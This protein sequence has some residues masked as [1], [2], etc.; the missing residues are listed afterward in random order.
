M[1]MLAATVA[2]GD[3]KRA[4]LA[5]ASAQR[6]SASVNGAAAIEVL[7]QTLQQARHVARVG[8]GV[9]AQPVECFVL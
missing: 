3:G 7:A 2:P 1:L 4:S 9:I 8:V 6:R 5:S